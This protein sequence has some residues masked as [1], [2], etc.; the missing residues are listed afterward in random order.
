MA[1]IPPNAPPLAKERPADAN[2]SYCPMHEE[3]K[4]LPEHYFIQ[5]ESDTCLRIGLTCIGGLN[6]RP[7][8]LHFYERGVE[9]FLVDK[10]CAWYATL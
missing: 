6:I 4:A 5:E 7:L 8:K 3:I 2:T 10:P 9:R 1:L